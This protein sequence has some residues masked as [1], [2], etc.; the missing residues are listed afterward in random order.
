MQSNSIISAVGDPAR[1]VNAMR[2]IVSA[3][4]F[5]TMK[6]PILAGRAFSSDDRKQTVPV[7]VLSDTAARRLFGAAN[8]V[9]LSFAYESGQQIQVAGV[10]H[11]VRA[12]N[13]REEFLPILYLPMAQQDRIMLLTA[14]LRTAGN[15][16]S[17]LTAVKDAVHEEMPA[18]R[19]ESAMP[20]ATMLDGMM[21]QERMLALLS[22]AFG[23]MALLLASGGLYGV[24]AYSVERRTRELGIR[25][26]LGAER[27][28]VTTML[29][30]EIGRLLAIGFLF[31]LAGTLALAR[32]F[33]SLLFGITPHD[34]VT[35]TAAAALLSAVGLAAGYVPARRAGQLDPMEAL[36][37]Q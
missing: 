31:G 16:A 8:P 7:A 17:F 29:L 28:R 10:A 23:L 9:G 32:G 21:Q 37:V 5:E 26:A 1:T 6:I 34:P 36:R 18:I 20:V 24:I 3:H 4:Y 33:Q 27:A 13:P 14:E 30:A 15:P 19:I 35:L 12:H 22:G 25:L 11:D 2:A